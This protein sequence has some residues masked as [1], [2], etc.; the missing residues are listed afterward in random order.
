MNDLL[1]VKTG[2]FGGNSE[3]F[4]FFRVVASLFFAIALFSSPSLALGEIRI[5]AP[6]DT[7]G[8]NYQDV[9]IT[10]GDTATLEVW[11]EADSLINGFSFFAKYDGQG[12]KL[13]EGSSASDSFP[14]ASLGIQANEDHTTFGDVL[15]NRGVWNGLSTDTFEYAALTN[16]DS[17]SGS[18][19]AAVLSFVGQSTGTWSITYVFDTTTNKITAITAANGNAND[20]FSS[21]DTGVILITV[22][23]T[24]VILSLDFV[25]D[26]P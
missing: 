21:G 18:Y 1:R 19:R 2:A 4:R 15:R 9:S 10:I 24:P 20:L 17:V 12:L 5:V 11:V 26:T 25:S 23:D 7:S 22:G 13:M 14:P 16:S 3:R 8:A 6:S